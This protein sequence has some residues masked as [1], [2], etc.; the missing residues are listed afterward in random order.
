[1]TIQLSR[2]KTLL[3]K[4]KIKQL[5]TSAIFTL[6]S[7]STLANQTIA[8]GIPMAENA[9]V[10]NENSI[11]VSSKEGIYH[12]KQTNGNWE[13]NLLTTQLLDGTVTSN[14]QMGGITQLSDISRLNNQAYTVCSEGF[15]NPAATSR[16]LTFDP[17][18]N[19]PVV[20]EVSEIDIVAPNGISS[21]TQGNLYIADTGGFFAFSGSLKKVQLLEN[22]FNI[23][24]NVPT[25]ISSPSVSQKTFQNFLLKR[26]NGVRF[27]GNRLYLSLVP[28]SFV[29]GKSTINS[30][31]IEPWGLGDKRELT[32]SYE[33]LDDFCFSAKGLV[34]TKFIG[35][36]VQQFDMSGNFVASQFVWLPTSVRPYSSSDNSFVVTS[37]TGN[38]SIISLS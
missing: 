13:K 4:E 30:Y 11:F 12:L 33:F 37:Q 5:I 16:L 21:D 28:A 2:F 36:K 18:A 3:P 7:H 32:S 25:A 19:T 10:I 27:Q 9:L 35:Q 31:R 23:N 38:V 14:C 6:F 1:M 29:V 20:T 34:T 17:Y 8:T 22:G 26:P 24:T 15:G